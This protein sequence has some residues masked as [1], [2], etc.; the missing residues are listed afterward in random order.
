M[1][2]LT[3]EQFREKWGP[4]SPEEKTAEQIF[5]KRYG[6]MA[7]EEKEN[8]KEIFYLDEKGDCIIPDEVIERNKLEGLDR[9]S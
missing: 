2:N 9:T 5:E 3:W 8:F 6:K 7:P 1:E 4:K